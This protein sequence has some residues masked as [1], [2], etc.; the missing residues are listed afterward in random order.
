LVVVVVVVPVERAAF[1]EGMAALA[2]LITL[3]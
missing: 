1:P 2:D 3:Y